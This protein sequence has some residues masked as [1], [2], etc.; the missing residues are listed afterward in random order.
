MDIDTFFLLLLLRHILAFG[1]VF[2]SRLESRPL[3][4][5]SLHMGATV[6]F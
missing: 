1:G 4:K 5:K 6:I 2:Q 3:V